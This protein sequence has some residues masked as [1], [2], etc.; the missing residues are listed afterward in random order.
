MLHPLLLRSSFCCCFISACFL[1]KVLMV[2][3][4]GGARK[5][6]IVDLVED[7]GP[8]DPDEIVEIELAETEC[9]SPRLLKEEMSDVLFFWR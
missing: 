6:I 3:A 9:V 2:V 5:A 8:S 4:A 1:A 7:Y